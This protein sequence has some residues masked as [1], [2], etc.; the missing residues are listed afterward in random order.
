SAYAIV[1]F[2]DSYRSGY[3]TDS[4][5]ARLGLTATI[6]SSV[7]HWLGWSVAL[8]GA[9]AVFC[10]IMIYGFTRREFWS[11]ARVALRFVLTPALLGVA[12][13]WLTILGLTLA[14]PSPELSELIQQRGRSL[15]GALI[16]LSAAKLTYE[17]AIF[18]HLLAW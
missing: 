9:A 6:I 12:V 7:I 4:F 1:V 3:G 10:S 8:V 13:V 5:F 17:A 15:C 14:H 16:A 11:F 2:L 18:K